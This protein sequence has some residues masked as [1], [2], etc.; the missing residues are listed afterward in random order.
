MHL[1][2]RNKKQTLPVMP[3]N[4][5]KLAPYFVKNSPSPTHHNLL[6]RKKSID[7]ILDKH[8][9]R[10]QNQGLVYKSFRKT[11]NRQAKV[12]KAD[13]ALIAVYGFEKEEPKAEIKAMNRNKSTQIGDKA[14]LIRKRSELTGYSPY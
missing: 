14:E 10:S 4:D 3:L 13:S 2:Y 5:T 9:N 7:V 8:V 1:A 12:Q 11:N 6:A